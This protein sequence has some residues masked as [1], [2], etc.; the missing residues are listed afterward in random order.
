VKRAV[1][2]AGLAAIG[3][4]ET[5]LIRVKPAAKV[6]SLA[7]ED[8]TQLFKS[9]CPSGGTV[10]VLIEP[11]EL[12]PMLAIFGRTPIAEAI[13][14]HAA[15]SG[16][17]LALPAE[18][19]GP[20]GATRFADGDIAALGLTARDFVVVASQ[21]MQDLACLRAALESPA[22]RISM[23]ASRRKADALTAKLAA[24]GMEPARIARLKSPAGLDLHGIDPQ[25]IAI[26]VLAEIVLWRN[27]DRNAGSIR[28]EDR[29]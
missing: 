11:Y 19:A 7:D 10:D 3:S 28:H 12:P 5:R 20:E 8:G 9:G 26:S 25:E 2:S 6:V 15:I 1:T 4:G 14:A 18:A 22:A 23:V 29:A 24:E 21:G 16:Y 17:R 27:T 13:A